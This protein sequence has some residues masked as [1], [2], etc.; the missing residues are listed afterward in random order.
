MVRAASGDRSAQTQMAKR[1]MSLAL[2]GAADMGDGIVE[3]TYWA[4]I[5]EANGGGPE[6]RQYLAGLLLLFVGVARDR[7]R[8]DISRLH[9]A[10]A[11]ARL[12]ALADEGDELAGQALAAFEGDADAGILA[13][14]QEFRGA[15]S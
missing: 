5:A 13:L 11:I 8:L 6:E 10:E 12:D 9:F 4:R 3:A 1:A 7:G 14:A 2:A 15:R